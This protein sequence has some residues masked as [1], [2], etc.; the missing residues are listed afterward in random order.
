MISLIKVSGG[1]ITVINPQEAG[2]L[3]LIVIEMVL[4]P[5]VMMI[6]CSRLV[7]N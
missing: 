2:V 7:N 3:I 1:T 6:Q 4:G 5:L